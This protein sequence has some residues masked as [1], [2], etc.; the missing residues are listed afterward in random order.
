VR[1]WLDDERP[2]PDD[3]WHWVRSANQFLRIWQL[4]NGKYD[5]T[6]IS[7]DHDLASYNQVT[8]DEITGYHCLCAVEKT[9]R[10]DADYVPPVMH[11]HSANPVGRIRMQKL[12]DRMKE[13][14]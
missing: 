2:P 14:P 11:V 12:I 8:G 5:V 4:G 10:Y 1:L 3:T 7:F 13:S 6:E 9:W